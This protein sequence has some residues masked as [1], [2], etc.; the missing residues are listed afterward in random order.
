M[1]KKAFITALILKYFDPALETLIEPNTNDSIVTAILSQYHLNTSAYT[2]HPIAFY[3][4][5]MT[6]AEYNYGIGDKELLVI[7]NT[8]R[9]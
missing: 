1:L 8:F 9:E 4:R 7:I 5:K 2:L 3:S 6:A